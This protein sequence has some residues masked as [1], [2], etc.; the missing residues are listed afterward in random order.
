[1][2]PT[3]ACTHHVGARDVSW[4]LAAPTAGWP[5]GST[6]DGAV[7][8]PCILALPALL[9]NALSCSDQIA[10]LKFGLPTPQ[11]FFQLVLQVSGMPKP[12]LKL[13]A[14]NYSEYDQPPEV[15]IAVRAVWLKAVCDMFLPN[16]LF[17]I[18]FVG[19]FNANGAYVR[20]LRL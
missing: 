12:V 8:V 15:H 4:L 16:M 3:L 13:A 9:Y 2:W 11:T 17:V 6:T 1:M 5:C 18:E 7:V 19:V 10:P 20:S 14:I